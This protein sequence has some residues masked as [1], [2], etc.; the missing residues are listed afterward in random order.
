MSRTSLALVSLAVA[1]LLGLDA[2]AAPPQ[3]ET[4]TKI[5]IEIRPMTADLVSGNDALFE[6]LV[7][8]TSATEAAVTTLR[9]AWPEPESIS[10]LVL[11][12]VPAPPEPGGVYGVSLDAQLTLPNGNT[13]NARRGISLEERAT[14][15]FEVYRVGRR[16]LTLALELEAHRETVVL[17][18]RAPGSAVRFRVEV[19]R[20][21]AGQQVSLENNYLNTLV[22]EPVTYSFRLGTTPDVD[23]VSVTLTPTRLHASVAEI[24]VAVAGRLPLPGE[25]A[26]ISRTEHWLASRDATSKLAFE[27][28]EP[29]TGY[30][31]LVTARF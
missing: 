21:T 28:G 30:R 17:G 19:V 31:F 7:L 2:R 16:A 9:L 13:V 22:G 18:P 24:D 11:R 4:R 6:K 26:V 12:A 10:T 14:T 5:E 15:L 23:A 3:L 29:P 25:L 8:D 20:V 1:P 27:S